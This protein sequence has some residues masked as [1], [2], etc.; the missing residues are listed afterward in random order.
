MNYRPI[1]LLNLDIKMLAKILALT[2]NPIIG[3]LVHRWG[4]SQ[5]AKPVITLDK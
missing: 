3:G 5:D 4:S 2:H 1:S